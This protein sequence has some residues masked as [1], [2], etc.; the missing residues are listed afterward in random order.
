MA[1]R[2]APTG[3]GVFLGPPLRPARHPAPPAMPAPLRP[4][5]LALVLAA[6]AVGPGCA[7]ALTAASSTPQGQAAI[8]RAVQTALVRSGLAAPTAVETGGAGR[9]AAGPMLADVTHRGAAVWV[10][11]DGPT[12][13]A[14][15]VRAAGGA[16][17]VQTVAAVT[18][19]DGTATLRVDGLEP[20][21][22]YGYAVE[23]GGQAVPF[24]YPTAFTTQALWQWRTDPPAFT[25]AFGSCHYTNDPAYD[26]PGDPYGGPTAIFES[27]RRAS[28]DLMLWLGDNVYLREVDWWSPGGID[29]RYAHS[30][31]QPDLQPLLAAVPHYA[32]WDDHDYGPNNSDRSYV[33]KGAALDTFTRYWPAA[34]RG[35]PGVP[36]VFTQFEWADVE[37][38]LL[39]DRYH[40]A[41]NDAPAP[42][43]TVLGREQLLWVLDA[44]T[45][46]RAPFKV[47]ALG[48]QVLN[49][50]PVFETYAAVAPAERAFLLDQIRA[51]GIDGVVFLSGDRHHAELVRVERPGT[52]PLY[53]FTSSPL[54]AGVSTAALDPDSP[55]YENPARVPG[56]LVADRRNFGTLTV[57]GPRTDRTMT[58]RALGADGVVLWERSVR[59]ADLRTPR[60]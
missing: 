38:L 19:P 56:T 34:A 8:E 58:M 54:T 53:E 59:A 9:L 40:R 60:D 46:S 32:T 11:T 55:E 29:D 30:R 33:L 20:G 7:P 24:P 23:V 10:Q 25:V 35:L 50:A 14:L 41:P 6:L 2:R 31:A 15:T 21:Q 18:G 22:T 26:R 16:E 1:A 4:A 17:V 5:L 37:F 42:E 57:S 47:V 51:R 39:D 36:G 49:P 12:D 44:L 43:R 52:Y 48:G 28:P 13:V 3:R 27:I 45:A